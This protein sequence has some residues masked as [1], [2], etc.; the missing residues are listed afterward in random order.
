VDEVHRVLRD[1]LDQLEAVC[2]RALQLLELGL[3]EL[4]ELLF[5]E[6]EALHHLGALHDAVV[7]WTEVLLLHSPAALLVQHVEAHVLRRGRSKELE[8]DGDEAKADRA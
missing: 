8:R 7:D 1:E 4:D 6:L 5:R 3:V 2:L